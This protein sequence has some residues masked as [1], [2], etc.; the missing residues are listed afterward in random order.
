MMKKSRVAT[1]IAVVMLIGLGGCSAE[2]AVSDLEDQTAN[3]LQA[4]DE[5]VLAVKNGT[6]PSYPGRTY[7]EAFDSY[8]SEAT[9]KYFKGT[10]DKTD[11]D[12]TDTLDSE[13]QISDV[14][15]FTGYCMYKDVT[16]KALIQFTL[17]DETFKATYLS[18]NEVP[19]NELILAGL[20]NAVFTD[21]D[22]EVE[23]QEDTQDMA[24]GD[25]PA[26][27]E[28]D[29]YLYLDEFIE[30]LYTFSDFPDFQTDEEYNEYY[31]EQ[32]QVWEAGKGYYGI[33]QGTDGKLYLVQ[34]PEFSGEWWDTYSQRCAITIE[35]GPQ[36][37]SYFYI[38]INWGSSAWENTC[39]SMSG[40]YDD[41]RGGIVYNDGCEVYQQYDDAGNLQEKTLYTGGT[42]LLYLDGNGCLHWQ[43]DM[44]HAGD[45]CIFE[46][47]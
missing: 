5:H 11:E 41:E 1:L 26:E 38:Q 19:Q 28:E 10:T 22:I 24:G 27:T 39:W 30:L 42:G 3:V 16:V 33:R 7:G 45:E 9:W 23:K 31:K 37:N 32:Y 4:E 18:F 47:A 2:S 43:D 46:R 44:E 34:I 20:I 12:E 40:Y 17:E 6:N 35:R 13:K 36:D 14:V 25:D 21:D 8:F 29:E 15:E